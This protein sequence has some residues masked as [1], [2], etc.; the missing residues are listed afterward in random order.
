MHRLRPARPLATLLALAV[1]LPSFAQDPGASPGVFLGNSSSIAVPVPA[2]LAE[3]GDLG[4]PRTHGTLEQGEGAYGIRELV[5]R[6]SIRPGEMVLMG[7]VG[8]HVI[9]PDGNGNVEAVTHDAKE[10]ALPRE[11]T[12]GRLIVYDH[13]HK[14]GPVSGAGGYANA[15]HMLLDDAAKI[16]AHAQRLIDA[17]TVSTIRFVSHSPPDLDSLTSHLVMEEIVD[18][19]RRGGKFSRLLPD[20][21]RQ[22]AANADR[23]ILG[24]PQDVA[25][26]TLEGLI[27]GLNREAGQPAEQV[28]AGKNFLQK[29]MGLAE[30]KPWF[31]A[32]DPKIPEDR[33]PQLLEELKAKDAGIARAAARTDKI[34]REILDLKQSAEGSRGEVVRGPGELAQSMAVR[35]TWVQG[36]NGGLQRVK[37]ATVE[38]NFL[39]PISKLVFHTLYQNGVDIV[40]IKSNNAKGINYFACINGKKTGANLKGLMDPVTQRL[41]L[42]D[43]GNYGS[44]INLGRIA[45]EVNVHDLGRETAE[46]NGERLKQAHERA[47][48]EFPLEPGEKLRVS[49]EPSSG[50]GTGGETYKVEAVREGNQAREVGS[51]RVEVAAPPPAPRPGERASPTESKVELFHRRF[52]ERMQAAQVKLGEGTRA[53]FRGG[54]RSPAAVQAT[55]LATMYLFAVVQVAQAEP[56]LSADEILAKAGEAAFSKEALSALGAFLGVQVATQQGGRG[57]AGL[58]GILTRIGLETGKEVFRWGGRIVGGAAVPAGVAASHAVIG[59][60]EADRLQDARIEGVGRNIDA[61]TLGNAQRAAQLRAVAEKY[62]EKS[63]VRLLLESMDPDRLDYTLVLLEGFGWVLG[64]VAG[65]AASGGNP[66]VGFVAGASAATGVSLLYEGITERF[67]QESDAVE[68]ADDVVQGVTAGAADLETD[69]TPEDNAEKVAALMRRYS[70]A[71]DT[72]FL[73]VAQGH[74]QANRGFQFLA[75]YLR[76]LGVVALGKQ[77]YCRER[78]RLLRAA[79]DKLRADNGGRASFRQQVTVF[80]AFNEM[81]PIFQF[82]AY[83]SQTD[84]ERQIQKLLQRSG[85]VAYL[86]DSGVYKNDWGAL[87]P[88]KPYAENCDDAGLVVRRALAGVRLTL[89]SFGLR[90]AGGASPIGE[91][92]RNTSMGPALRKMWVGAAR[93]RA[94]VG[95]LERISRDEQTRVSALMERAAARG[96]PD[97]FAEVVSFQRALTA[98]KIGLHRLIQDGLDSK[99]PDLEFGVDAVLSDATAQ[100]E[101]ALLPLRELAGEAV[102]DEDAAGASAVVGGGLFGIGG[103]PPPATELLPEAP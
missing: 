27:E 77:R 87:V 64:Q 20:M 61:A 46:V 81:E 68:D 79:M 75:R 65:T 19:I 9:R 10:G 17:G 99:L 5:E 55:M 29:V 14:A 41:G 83:P 7:D 96:F 6:L 28:R 53:F 2:T 35:E 8:G 3:V 86:G 74:G 43:G 32:S 4:F 37:I 80:Q 85:N 39:N 70:E 13:H 42:F 47:A 95:G 93:G 18:R 102:Q 11:V 66:V 92:I 24:R 34:M 56:G 91:T 94:A 26:S 23:G 1:A 54:S 45:D 90:A 25:S 72:L 73:R 30:T 36:A 38:V 51:V 82:A 50:E 15:A 40:L 89:R 22:H 84:E 31:N 48:R 52:A 62:F 57:I 98:E 88:E 71:Y 21:A 44:Q 33:V 58:S 12:E 100:W 16:A 59:T 49:L 78:D 97:G 76:D 69:G 63:T 60:Y 67:F 103:S 101:L